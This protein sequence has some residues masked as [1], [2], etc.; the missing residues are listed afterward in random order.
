MSEVTIC[1]AD[2]SSGSIGKVT[3]YAGVGKT[4]QEC[5]HPIAILRLCGFGEFACGTVPVHTQCMH[6]S[7]HMRSRA[8][9]ERFVPMFALSGKSELLLGYRAS[10]LGFV[11]CYERENLVDGSQIVEHFLAQCFPCWRGEV[12]QLPLIFRQHT[13]R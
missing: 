10:L 7:R 5:E 8:C 13:T 6:G 2:Q 12:D 1:T 3:G 9:L 11:G 4:W